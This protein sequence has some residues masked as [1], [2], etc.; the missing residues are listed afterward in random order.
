M[1]LRSKSETPA[2]EQAH[3]KVCLIHLPP[4]FGIMDHYYTKSVKEF[5][6]ILYYISRKSFR[7]V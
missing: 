7:S 4:P 5:G 3:L 6:F 1:P 2:S